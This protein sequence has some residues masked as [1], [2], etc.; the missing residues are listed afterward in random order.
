MTLERLFESVI[1]T[2][3]ELG[4][5]LCLLLHGLSNFDCSGLRTIELGRDE[6]RHLLK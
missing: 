6:E 2:S 3:S 5:S 1:H 4:I